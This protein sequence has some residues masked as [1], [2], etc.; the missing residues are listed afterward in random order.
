VDI[1]PLYPNDKITMS[2]RAEFL[3]MDIM[4]IYPHNWDIY[5]NRSNAYVDIMDI[6]PHYIHIYISMAWI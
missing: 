4:D 3:Y 1:Y 6:Y 5:P 2:Q